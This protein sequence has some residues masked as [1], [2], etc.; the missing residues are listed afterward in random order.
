MGF[1]F[2]SRSSVRALGL[3]VSLLTLAFLLPGGVARP[4]AA[5]AA[6]PPPPPSPT[7]A[8]VAQV[9]PPPPIPLDQRD[10]VPAAKPKTDIQ[11]R[12]LS[13]P[14][15][16][17]SDK[18]RTNPE[19]KA[20]ATET[21]SVYKL[22]P[23]DH[24]LDATLAPQN[25][26]D[27][28]GTWK[29]IDS[30]LVKQTGGYRNAAG[31]ASVSFPDILTAPTPVTYAMPEGTVTFFPEGA[32]TKSKATLTKSN[33]LTYPNALPNID[34]RYATTAVG[35]AEDV[36]LKKKPTTDRFSWQ[37]TTE[38]PLFYRRLGCLSSSCFPGA[39]SR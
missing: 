5:K 19:D 12:A 7:A 31:P 13:V 38:S 37:V 9:F 28:A 10:P 6:P 30:T 25:F 24:L 2:F 35:Y 22:G 27:L 20:Q 15:G 14:A 8:Q 18:V 36:V 23:A 1:R 33:A 26:K 17:P 16:T 32:S 29:K 4:R 39:S 3:L 34:L 11:V 21:A